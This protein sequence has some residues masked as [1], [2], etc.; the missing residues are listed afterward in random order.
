MAKERP[1][2]EIRVG[3][4]KATIWRNEY[5]GQN[6]SRV[7]FNVQFSRLYKENGEARWK[8]TDSFGRDDL[9]VVAEVANRAWRHIYE[10]SN[11]TAP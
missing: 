7:R 11:A 10:A 3:K 6:G 2:K 1:H 9:P 8:T 4:V 5:P